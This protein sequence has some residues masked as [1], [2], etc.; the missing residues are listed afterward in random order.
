VHG[1]VHTGVSQEEELDDTAASPPK[2]FDAEKSARDSLD[3][4]AKRRLSMGFSNPTFENVDNGI[5]PMLTN[6]DTP[7]ADGNLMA[8]MDRTKHTKKAR[9]NSP[10][11]GSAGSLEES[12][13]SQ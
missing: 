10:S 4:G 8:D 1:V 6:A 12:V 13:Q 5:L 7:P 9:A 3:N 2:K 11:L